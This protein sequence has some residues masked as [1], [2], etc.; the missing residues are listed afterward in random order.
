[1]SLQIANQPYIWQQDPE[2]QK[3]YEARDDESQTLEADGLV[4]HSYQSGFD[5]YL[6]CSYYFETERGVVLI[7]TQLFYSAVRELW[8]QIQANTSGELY[9][10]INTHAHPDHYYGNAYIKKMAP[11]ALMV[12]SR[13]VMDD[14][15]RTVR[16]RCAK[17]NFDWGEE[18]FDDP[19]KIVLPNL[20]FD[21]RATLEF[22]NLTLELRDMGPSEAPV[23]LVGWIPEVRGI[24]AADILQ[25]QQHLY[26]VDRTL[27]PW[28]TIVQEFERWDPTWLLTG[29]QGIAGVELINETKRWI[30]TYL[31]VMAESLPAGVD[32]EDVSALDDDGRLG[33]LARMREAFPNWFDPYFHDG[34]TVMETC[35][36]GARSEVVGAAVMDHGRYR[37]GER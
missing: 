14:L 4:I 20:T 36:A 26:F 15:K 29:H 10:V 12:T 17:T 31:G 8:D 19:G 9:C 1:M 32:M 11:Q 35:M 2:W 3:W 13:A 28:Y 27:G 5:P 16:Q 33:V 6:T 37:E 18:V 30:A 21:E 23:Q 25:N 22:D 7:D 24:V 34:W